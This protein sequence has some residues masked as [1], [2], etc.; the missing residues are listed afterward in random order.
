MSLARRDMF[1][2]HQPHGS[3]SQYGKEITLMSVRPSVC[4]FPFYLLNRPSDLWPWYFACIWVI[5]IARRRR[6]RLWRSVR[7]RSCTDNSFSSCDFVPHPYSQ[8]A[9]ILCFTSINCPQLL[10]ANAGF[11]FTWQTARGWERNI[12]VEVISTWMW[13]GRGYIS[14]AAAMVRVNYAILRCILFTVL[15]IVL[16]ISV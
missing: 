15:Y 11:R 14:T 12:K 6:S 1:F 3:R 9:F 10:C 8:H 7:R 16:Q 2:R 4:F 13:A 5:I